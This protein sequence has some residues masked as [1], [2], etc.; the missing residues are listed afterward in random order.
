MG[1][2][3]EFANVEKIKEHFE[4]S[5]ENQLRGNSTPAAINNYAQFILEKLQISEGRILD[6]GCGDGRIMEQIQK[7]N[8]KLSIDGVELTSTL[9]NTARLLNPKSEIFNQ[10]AINL[11]SKKKY[12]RIFSFGFA[13]YLS[14]KQFLDLNNRLVL[15]LTKVEGA[16]IV[17]LS[18]PD[19]GLRNANYYV[20]YA[21]Q[22]RLFLFPG[23]FILNAINFKRS[24]G[25]DGSRYHDPRELT[26]MHNQNFLVEISRESDSYYRFDIQLKKRNS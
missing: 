6:V 9:S 4:N 24:Y 2:K 20:E 7:I 5:T 13:Q 1:S 3:N 15:F 21:K 17:H 23:R 19:W 11:D 26:K 12:D 8:P 14:S 16:K 18:I 25:N 22:N 10:N